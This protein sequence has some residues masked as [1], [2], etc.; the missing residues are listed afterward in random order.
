MGETT[1]EYFGR[2]IEME[3][4][5]YLLDGEGNASNAAEKLELLKEALDDLETDG[6]QIAVA[7][8]EAA[9][10]DGFAVGSCGIHVAANGKWMPD[11]AV[12]LKG[13]DV[14]LQGGISA[15]AIASAWTIV[16][17]AGDLAELSLREIDDLAG[18]I[19]GCIPSQAI[20]RCVILWSSA[21]SRRMD[22][23]LF[24]MGRLA[25]IRIAFAK[26]SE[27]RDGGI[28]LLY[29]ESD[30]NSAL[31]C[32]LAE[33]GMFDGILCKSSIWKPTKVAA[34]AQRMNE[35]S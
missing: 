32:K 16:V 10:D 6:S 28:P 31:A 13:R 4:L 1:T 15:E 19:S 5:L 22:Q 3:K 7:I 30:G 29:F 2:W 11:A 25:A 21:D 27:N 14:A 34:L 33:D 24:V 9:F 8:E 17:E 20:G 12:F 18:R 35:E 26:A 23:S